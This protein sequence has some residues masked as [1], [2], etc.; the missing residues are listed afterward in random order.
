MSN[1]FQNLKKT[2]PK[3]YRTTFRD[4]RGLQPQDPKIQKN[5]R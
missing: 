2:T 3:N 1:V 4:K 5:P